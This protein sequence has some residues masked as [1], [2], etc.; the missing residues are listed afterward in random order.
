M[1]GVLLRNHPSLENLAKMAGYAT[2]T[3]M[4]GTN[5]LLLLGFRKG[6]PEEIPLLALVLFQVMALEMAVGVPLLKGSSKRTGAFF[7]G[8]PLS[9]KALWGSHFLVSMLVMLGLLVFQA[10][11]VALFL[12]FMS[13]VTGNLLLPWGMLAEIF[14]RP[15]LVAVGVAG[16]MAAFRPDLAD[17]AQSPSWRRFAVALVLLA[18]LV[19]AGLNWL[20]LWVALGAAVAGAVVALAARGRVPAALVFDRNRGESASKAGPNE[21]AALLARPR[22][23]RGGGPRV[24]IH[25]MNQLY[26]V[27]YLWAWV[28]SVFIGFF[29]LIL[30][31]APL[32]S[33]SRFP[34]IMRLGNG[35][36]TIYI[37]FAFSGEFMLRL[38]RVDAL[39]VSR[40]ALMRYMVAPGLVMLLLSYGGGRLWV[41]STHPAQERIRFQDAHG[42]FGPAVSPAFN[43][44]TRRG[45]TLQVS[46]P[47]G[48]THQTEARH[49]VTF[50]GS[51][52]AAQSEFLTEGRTSRR[53]LAWQ[54][55]RAVEMVYG[56]SIDPDT[57]DRRYIQED[58]ETGPMVPRSSLTVAADF[59]LRPGPGG[60]VAPL[61]LAPIIGGWFLVMGLY[62]WLLQTTR[63]IRW[64][65]GAWWA[66]MAGLFILHL[67]NIL[68][69]LPWWNAFGGAVMVFSTARRLGEMGAGATG[70]V[71][72]A[73][74]ALVWVCWRFCTRM[75][76][77]VEAPRT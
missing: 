16:G 25:I 10:F 21:W 22:P 17:M 27:P 44:V 8:L 33:V 70:A 54:M 63:S 5:V 37:L 48:E 74:L 24:N 34:E 29:G 12:G 50:P 42:K 55:S 49:P 3:T 41:E 59:G 64:A 45:N 35:F 51:P 56:V 58:P 75:F 52:L 65:R 72:V 28:F 68:Q 18:E 19:L 46:A 7:L 66:F 1:T 60:P 71:Y 6:G 62:F 43:T 40:T 76:A 53:F 67:G 69:K 4:L 31:D 39:P 57:L 14:A 13:L 61:L 11:V 23:F 36:I 9:G 73:G 26:K 38:H 47:W 77:N 32:L 30:A 2:A 15:A 20:P